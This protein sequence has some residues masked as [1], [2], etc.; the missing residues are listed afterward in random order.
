MSCECRVI[1]SFG[2]N[3]PLHAAAPEL[4]QNLKY[5]LKLCANLGPHASE[6]HRSEA[7]DLYEGTVQDA[8]EAIHKAE[9]GEE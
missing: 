7:L 5:I 9:G 2:F 1:D 8:M 6:T 3:C 4:L